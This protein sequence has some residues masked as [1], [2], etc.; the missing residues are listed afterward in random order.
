MLAED[1]KRRVCKAV[2]DGAMGVAA[3][4]LL[5]EGI[6]D[7]DN[8]EVL[9]KLRSLHPPTEVPA[10]PV[11]ACP[12]ETPAR[13]KERPGSEK[14]LEAARQAVMGFRPGAAAGPSGLKPRHVQGLCDPATPNGTHLLA[15]L[16]AFVGVCLSGAIPQEVATCMGSANLIAMQKKGA[17][18]TQATS[19][20]ELESIQAIL[21]WCGS[22]DLVS[23]WD[24][25]WSPSP[26][27]WQ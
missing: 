27:P 10:V 7:P 20:V 1:T 9:A 14:R 2:E 25:D 23:L 24:V 4:Q 19:R 5:S 11:P 18:G 8:P 22:D 12:G 26:A 21:D 3:K 15:A 17:A 13:N 16:D 6:H